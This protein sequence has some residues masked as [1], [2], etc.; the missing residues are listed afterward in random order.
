MALFTV[1]FL[2]LIALLSVMKYR[3]HLIFMVLLLCWAGISCNSDNKPRKLKFNSD[4]HVKAELKFEQGKILDP[5]SVELEPDES[6]ALYL[7]EGYLTGYTWPTVLFFDPKGQ[8]HKPLK[9]YKDLAD[10]FGFILIG[11]NFSKN[12][13]PMEQILKHI[14]SLKHDLPAGI[15][16]DPFRIFLIGFSGGARVAVAEAMVNSD[17]AGVVGCGA[18]FPQ[19]PGGLEPSFN[20]MAMVGRQDF[21]Y[22]EFAV[23]DKELSARGSNHLL[24][25]FEGKHAWPNKKQML[26]AFKWMTAYSYSQREAIDMTLMDSLYKSDA[27]QLLNIENSENLRSVVQFYKKMIVLYNGRAKIE[28]QKK[29]LE[30]LTISS[31]YRAHEA[32]LKTMLSEEMKLRNKYAQQLSKKDNEWWNKEVVNI[33]TEI[34]NQSNVMV[35]NSRQRLLAYLSIATFMHIDAAL[36]KGLLQQAHKL[37]YILKLVDPQNPD[38]YYLSA[39]LALKQGKKER[40]TELLKEAVKYGF[41]DWETVNGE[42]VF[43]PIRSYITTMQ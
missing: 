2:G 34:E 21:N 36:K 14:N 22:G 42:H 32:E 26:E 10:D 31:A 27:K 25:E 17:V 12:G 37:L 19:L 33:R 6:Y 4:A 1:F 39:K 16:I 15:K 29:R 40:A 11:S 5:L 38:Y 20:Y 24:I 3:Q 18:G 23:L 8:G 28:I 43:D 13:K 41:D 35:K 7:P 30:M 9:L